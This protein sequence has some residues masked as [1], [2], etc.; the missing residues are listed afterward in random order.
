MQ[1]LVLLFV[2]TAEQLAVKYWNKGLNCAQA[3]ACSVLELQGFKEACVF[4]DA[5]KDFG[6]GF[7]EGSMCGA[8]IGGIAVLDTVLSKRNSPDSERER[9]VER[10][11]ESFKDE[12]HAT[13]CDEL[14]QEFKTKDRNIDFNNPLRE[15]KCIKIVV[16][17][18]K[19]VQ[20]LLESSDDVSTAI[21]KRIR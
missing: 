7:G 3:V 19:R 11:K 10:F 2:V 15:K 13:N 16:T 4:K 18:T 6:R 21:L 12:F 8:V 17:A 20:R 14:L 5:F 1:T 9:I